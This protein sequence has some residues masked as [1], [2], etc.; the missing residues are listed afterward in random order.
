MD[1]HR[2]AELR[3]L[4]YHRA[5][6]TRL[7]GQ[8]SLLARARRRVA[9]WRAAG[10]AAPA[11]TDAWFEV[12]CRDTFSVAAF[13]TEDSEYA[14]ALRQSSPFAGAL[15]AAERWRIWRATSLAARGTPGQ[16]DP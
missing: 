2:R 8:P 12:L 14:R 4:A 5:I 16:V 1:P 13:L 10:L 3:S 7:A 9:T 15:P 11:E 6:A